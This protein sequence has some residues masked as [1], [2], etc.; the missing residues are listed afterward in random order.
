MGVGALLIHIPESTH[1]AVSSAGAW[2]CSGPISRLP[3]ETSA[4]I[5]SRDRPYAWL[6]QAGESWASFLE[7]RVRS[8]LREGTVPSWKLGEKTTLA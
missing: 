7:L 8:Q 2:R 4:Q 3:K 5:P 1:P 6:Q